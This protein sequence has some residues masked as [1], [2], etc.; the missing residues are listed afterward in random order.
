MN[1]SLNQNCI[2]TTS[3]N[4]FSLPHQPVSLIAWVLPHV[5]AGTSHSVSPKNKAIQER[6]TQ[7]CLSSHCAPKKS[8]TFTFEA[9]AKITGFSLMKGTKTCSDFHKC[10]TERQLEFYRESLLYFQSSRNNHLFLLSWS[11]PPPE[12]TNTYWVL[13]METLTSE[14][15]NLMFTSMLWKYWC[16]FCSPRNAG[17]VGDTSAHTELLGTRGAFSWSVAAAPYPA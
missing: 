11:N 16:M 13:N 2:S 3:N 4:F 15:Q 7:S 6:E 17:T 1:C 12:R 10:F 8:N 5:R 9:P 14:T